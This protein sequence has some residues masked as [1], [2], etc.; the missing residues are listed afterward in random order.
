MF[1]K[2]FNLSILFTVYNICQYLSPRLI[3]DASIIHVN[4]SEWST[5]KRVKFTFRS[6]STFVKWSDVNK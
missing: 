1:M 5:Y 3:D 2:N 4:N 6:S